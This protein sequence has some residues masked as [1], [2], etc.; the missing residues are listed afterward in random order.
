MIKVVV[1]DMDGTLLNE[2][3]EVSEA[4]LEA[5]QKL[6]KKDIRFIISTG[7]HYKGTMS[8]LEKHNLKCDYIVASGAEVRDQESKVLKQVPMDHSSFEDILDRIKDFPVTARFCS[9][10]YD[11]AIGSE[12]EV[13]ESLILE[14]RHFFYDGSQ[15]DIESLPEFKQRLAHVK[16]I[17]SVEDL[18]KD[19][20]SIY[21]IFI[22][23][24][25]ESIILEIDKALSDVNGIASA[26]SFASNLELTHINA[27]KGIALKEYIEILGYNMD[28]VMVL[29]D[30]MNDY[31]MLSMDFGATVAME[32][33]MEQIKKVCKYM[34]KSNE[35]EGFAYAVEKMLNDELE[36]LRIR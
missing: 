7:R 11:Y 33:S 18:R 2:K 17:S 24:Q 20:I 12:E 8:T 35:E 9:D 36:E 1:T 16:C 19:N 22:F 30:S 23:S 14:A 34:T 4:S 25:D 3:H 31:S 13:K 28:E 26:S 10:Q 29:G 6:Y 21:K 32:N 15:D 5:I 27:Q